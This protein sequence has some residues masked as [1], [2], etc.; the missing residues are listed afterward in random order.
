MAGVI[1]THEAGVGLLAKRASERPVVERCGFGLVDRFLAVTGVGA[2]DAG[3]DGDDPGGAWQTRMKRAV[4]YI[5][6]SGRRV[7][8]TLKW[9]MT[10]ADRP[11]TKDEKPG[12]VRSWLVRRS[13]FSAF[14]FEFPRQS[15]LE[16][17]ARS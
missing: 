16:R 2:D 8:S 4:L 12:T 15:S 3:D 14:R 11:P 10:W 6:C 9:A 17:R 7:R 13:N 5:S 1:T